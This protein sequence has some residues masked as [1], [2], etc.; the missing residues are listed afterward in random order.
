MGAGYRYEDLRELPVIKNVEG[1]DL[2]IDGPNL[3]VW[4]FVEERDPEDDT[5]Y[6]EGLITVERH[7][8]EDGRDRWA[9]EDTSFFLYDDGHTE[10]DGEY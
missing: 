9:K 3:R 7:Y 10:M 5:S 2:R 1:S 8:V 4:T 6:D